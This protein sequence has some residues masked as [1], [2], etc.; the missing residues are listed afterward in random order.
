MEIHETSRT[1][2]PETGTF[3]QRYVKILYLEQ[4]G[5]V[6]SPRSPWCDKQHSFIYFQNRRE[7]QRASRD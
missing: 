4:P 5:H 7:E 6:Q 1:K 3:M 2:H